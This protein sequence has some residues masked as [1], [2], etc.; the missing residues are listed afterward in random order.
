[1]SHNFRRSKR[2]SGGTYILFLAPAFI[3]LS[4]RGFLWV[5]LGFALL[6][7]S[8]SLP[9]APV[10]AAPSDLPRFTAVTCGVSFS[11][12]LECLNQFQVRERCAFLGLTRKVSK[13]WPSCSQ[14]AVAR[15]LSS[16]R[17][18]DGASL[19]CQPLSLTGSLLSLVDTCCK[20]MCLGTE[21]A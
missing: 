12:E 17:L 19:L 9:E 16:Q 18:G 2:F 6:P 15:S 11:C 4:K 13:G 7:P 5:L 21:A 8:L 1:M 3:E 10:N 20:G 14:K